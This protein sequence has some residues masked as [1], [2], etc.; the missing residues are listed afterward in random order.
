MASCATK[1]GTL[2]GKKGILIWKE[3]VLQEREY[4]KLYDLDLLYNLQQN[5]YYWY[6]LMFWLKSDI[7]VH[8]IFARQ[9]KVYLENF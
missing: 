7:C 6:I 4:Q 9:E 5:Y 2:G 8:H 3:V 1:E